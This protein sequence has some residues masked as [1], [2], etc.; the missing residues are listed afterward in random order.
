MRNTTTHEEHEVQKLVSQAT[1]WVN[2]HPWGRT[3]TCSEIGNGCLLAI[4]WGMG[5]DCILV[6]KLDDNH[7][8]V[9]VFTTLRILRPDDAVSYSPDRKP[10]GN[11]N[12]ERTEPCPT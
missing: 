5:K 7:E 11:I 3:L 6:L 8:F 1:E 12:S 4:R 9:A 10:I 2:N